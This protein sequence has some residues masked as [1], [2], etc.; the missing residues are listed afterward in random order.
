VKEFFRSFKCKVFA[1]I[2]LVLIGLMIRTAT[3]GGLAS[4][5][6][7]AVSLIA[8]PVQK[9]TSSVSGFFGGIGNDIATFSTAKSENER[10][11]KKISDL[12][13]KIVNYDDIL[14]ENQQ[15]EA[16]NDI[17]KDNPD[18]KLKPAV[19]IS[20]EPEQWYSSLTIDKGSLDGVKYQDPV[21][22]SDNDL[23]GKV[24]QVYAHSSVV[25]TTLDPS[26]FA[27][28]IVSETGETGRA[29]GDL[30]LLSKE[31]FRVSSLPKDNAVS[32]GDIIVTSGTSG[33][34]PKNLK[35]GTVDR[36]ETDSTGIFTS[37][38]CKPMVSPSNL[39]NVFVLTN[40]NGKQSSSVS[41]S[42]GK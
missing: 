22:T 11:K 14:R 19:V 41:A 23:V 1:V 2:A 26:L 38:I 20:R 28:I 36:A 40:F 29:Q 31:E 6:A 24:M 16:A 15:L 9:L 7:D 12:Q 4:F 8:S 37:T 42:G 33:I 10:L 39:K 27:G 34:F 21:I 17:H 3:S 25:I 35:I 30:S 5:T 32:S 13:S 18:F